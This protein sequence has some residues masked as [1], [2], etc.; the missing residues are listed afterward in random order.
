MHFTSPISPR[1][2]RSLRV[3]FWTLLVVIAVIG[4]LVDRVN[5]NRLKEIA[6]TDAYE[7]VNL[8]R[9]KLESQ[10]NSNLQMV[11]GL[12]VAVSEKDNLNQAN[13]TKIAAPLFDHSQILR[14]IGAAPDMVIT[15]MYPLKGNEKAIGLDYNKVPVQREAAL[16]AKNSKSIVLA[17]PLKLV[18][19]GEALIAR[20]PVF[21]TESNQFWGLLSVV[22]DIEKLYNAVDLQTLQD[23]FNV[24]LRKIDNVN[25]D[26]KGFFLGSTNLLNKDALVLKINLPNQQD[27]ELYAYPKAGWK[28]DSASL[29]SF[30]LTLL[31]F[32]CLFTAAFVF[33]NRIIK[34]IQDN[35]QHLNTMSHLAE[36][37]AW[38]VDMRTQ[39]VFCSEVTKA[40]F[41]TPSNFQPGWLNSVDFF[42][43]GLHRRRIQEFMDR[44]IKLAQPFEDEFLITTDKGNMRWISIKAFPRV[45]KGRTVEVVGSLQNIDARKKIELEHDKIARHNELLARITTHE[46]LLGNQLDLAHQLITDAVCSGLAAARSTVWLFDEN[47]QHLIPTAFSHT[48]AKAWEQFP[49]WRA[50]ALKK[51][52]E[53]IEK[54]ELIALPDARKNAISEPLVEH[55]LNPFEIQSLYISP[56]VHHGKAVGILN[57]EY[58]VPNP[59]WTPSDTRFIKALAV[60]LGSLYANKET[61]KSKQLALVQ[62]ELAEQSA[63]MKAEFLASMSHEIRT[64]MNGI[65]GMMT[66]LQQTELTSSQRHQIHLAQ[67][68]AESLLT[69]INDILDFSK[70][71]AGKV[72]IDHVDVD[73][74]SLLSE[75][76]ESFALK[77]EEKQTLLEFD[78]RN[79]QIA[80]AKTDPHRLRQVLNNLLSNAVKFTE[81]GKIILTCYS[82]QN[83]DETRLWCSVE[84][85]G[86]GIAKEK[87]ATIF[88][89]FTQADS[90]TTRKYGGTGLGLSIAS[91]LCELLGG[92]LSAY[93][94]L[95]IG[96][97]FTFYIVLKEPV[98]IEPIDND[99]LELVFLVP[100]HVATTSMRHVLAPW[101]I[102][103]TLY[104]DMTHL[105][106]HLQANPTSQSLLILDPV[107]LIESQDTASL[108]HTITSRQLA[109]AKISTS[110]H[111]QALLWQDLKP[112]LDM[113]YPLTPANALMLYYGEPELQTQS[114][115]VLHGHVLLVEDNKVNQIVATSLLTKMGLT[116]SVVEHGVAAL[117]ILAADHSFDLVLMDCQMPEMDGYEATSRIRRGEAGEHAKSIAII[118]LTANAMV[119]DKE[120]CL[121]AGMD[122]YLSKPLQFDSL[123]AAIAQWIRQASPISPTRITTNS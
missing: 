104:H 118:A 67:S 51:L 87:L 101:H 78:C 2:A 90:S 72:E 94:K 53:T 33:L 114:D 109:F 55:Y 108:K 35:E 39:E 117:Q 115:S 19:G 89:S 12:A 7:E 1:K 82:E 48:K 62:K 119:G 60:V 31:T 112:A 71:E 49:P 63:K 16:Q 27:W 59:N 73:L 84:D 74:V 76:I 8:Y 30:R 34:Q 57:V 41:E 10:I 66:V 99:A 13:F 24:G 123:K 22:I 15:W 9:A 58:N 75:T 28:A 86:I 95:N 106:Q 98:A 56:I 17:G 11:R 97:T 103:T 14:N 52:F 65:L 113:L 70:I 120:K 4:V 68:S 116:V 38:S 26:D 96:S 50:N 91:Q 83:A 80:Q 85:T 43:Q 6:R 45:E 18:Q 21:E 3:G 46:A 29:W 110:E 88:D 79:L 44:A 111:S 61:L 93:S 42:E 107:M 102:K 40:I 32:L 122:A 121:A 23:R 47:K 69:I 37:G 100:D 81:Q 54:E 25:N 5:I 105:L 64:P 20:V 77:A 36:V 92:S